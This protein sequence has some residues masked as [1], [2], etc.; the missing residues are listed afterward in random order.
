[1]AQAICFQCDYVVEDSEPTVCEWAN[2]H[3]DET[4]HKV[5]VEY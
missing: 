4:G 1:M 3:T 2:E 5:T